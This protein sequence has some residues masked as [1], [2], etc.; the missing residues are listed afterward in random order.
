MNRALWRKAIGDAWLTLLGCGLLMFGFHWLF[1]WITSLIK[2]G[3]FR[4][5][6][7]KIPPTFKRLPGI[8][9]EELAT[10]A[11]RLSMAYLDPVVYFLAAAWGIARG[12]DSVAGELGRGTM[13]MLLAQPVRRIAVLGTQIAVMLGGAAVLATAAWLGTC[14][15]LATVDLGAEVD[16]R[17][18]LPAAVNLFALIGFTAGAST[19]VSSWD[20][21]RWR[22]IGVMASFYLVEFVLKVVSRT[23]EQLEWVSRLTFHGAYL[24]Q[25]L[26]TRP[27]DAWSLSL[28]LDGQLLGLGAAAFALAAVI[29]C[30]RDLPA[31]L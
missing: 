9:I 5:M 23:T 29:F 4:D 15:G 28:Q 20:R 8:S 3:D 31:P 19:L 14:T 6:L 7:D 12:S 2:L 25:I 27:D 17:L 21:Y 26:V 30:R 18:F 16:P 11:G 24:P 1:V 22:A 10:H 13:E